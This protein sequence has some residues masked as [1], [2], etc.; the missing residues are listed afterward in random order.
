M[1]H[2]ATPFLKPALACAALLALLLAAPGSGLQLHFG[3]ALAAV[4][5]GGAVHRPDKFDPFVRAAI[6]VQNWH[7]EWLMRVP[8]IVGTAT[9]VGPGGKPVIKVFTTRTG[10]PEIPAALDGVP[11]RVEMTG[12][13]VALNQHDGDPAA[14]HPR[15]VPIGVSTGHP[16]ITAGTIGARVRDAA[17]NLYILSNNHVLADSNDARI[18]DPALQPGP[19]DGG[20]V[21]GDA[22]GTLADYVPIDFSSDGENRVDAAIARTSETQQGY[23]TPSNG[24]GVP[25]STT[26]IAYIGQDVQ[27]Y[28]RTSGWTTGT[29][30]EINVTINVCYE[31]E[32]VYGCAKLARFVDQVAIS[33]AGFGAG[34]DSGSLIVTDDAGKNPVALLFAVSATRTIGSP[35]DYAL[36]SLNVTIDGGSSAGPGPGNCGPISLTAV[37]YKV[38]GIKRVDLEWGCATTAQVDIYRTGVEGDVLISTAN[39]G[40]HTDNTGSR[41]KGDF[42]YQ[43]CESNGGACSAPVA[44]SF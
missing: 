25:G 19:Y 22:I 30:S 1:K 3:S 41:G 10:I 42:T 21:P 43:V 44:V 34:G 31:P 36:N 20:Q 13:F 24:Y 35:I 28:G 26:L 9:G 14:W 23:S 2:L 8:G 32:D 5:S 39:D 11:V 33:P 17:G 12:R 16:A 6:E 27:K 29:V 18:D 7:T 40:V 4:N 15:P 37:G 38:K